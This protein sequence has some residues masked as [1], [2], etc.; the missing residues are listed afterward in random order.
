MQ[1]NIDSDV[2][3]M[4]GPDIPVERDHTEPQRTSQAGA[5]STVWSATPTPALLG[6]D[7]HSAYY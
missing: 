2:A 6:Q 5:K 3:L 4:A 1:G 7:A